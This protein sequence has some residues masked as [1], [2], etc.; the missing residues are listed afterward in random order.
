MNPFKAAKQ[1]FI[2]SRRFDRNVQVGF[3]KDFHLASLPDTIGLR[4]SGRTFYKVYLN[5]EFVFYGP[6]RAAHEHARVDRIDV[7]NQVRIGDNILAIEVA[8]YNAG[9][10]YVTGEYSFLMAE[11]EADGRMLLH[12]DADWSGVE[13]KQK[14][15]YAENYSHARCVSEIYDLD[16]NYY[17]WRTLDQAAFTALGIPLLPTEVI[18]DPLTFLVRGAGTPDYQTVKYVRMINVSSVEPATGTDRITTLPMMV[19]TIPETP[20]QGPIERPVIDCKNDRDIPFSGRL[21]WGDVSGPTNAQEL[22][23]FNDHGVTAVDFDFVEMASA[24]PGLEFTADHPLTVDLI[25]VDK[26]TP[27]GNFDPLNCY[28]ITVIRLHCEAGRYRFEAFEPYGVRYLRVVVRG[29]K[30]FTLHDV[31]LRRCQYP[32]LKGGSFLCS[33]SALNRIYDAA[34]LGLRMNTFDN[35]MD[36]PGRERGGWASDSFWTARAARLLY[37]DTKVERAHLEN[38]LAGSVSK[39]FPKNIPACYPAQENCCIQNWTLFLGLEL[40]EYYRRTADREFL[41]DRAGQV[42]KL[43]GTL[44]Q[45]ENKHGLLE[46]LA[47][48]IYV[49]GTT[50]SNDLYNRPISTATNATY[51]VMLQ[52]LGEIYN[53][54]DWIATAD[55]ILTV[56]KQVC[57]IQDT[58]DFGHY[59]PD[60]FAMDDAGTITS[61]KHSSE[62][63]QYLLMWLGLINKTK[64]PGLCR[65]MI[66]EFGVNPVVPFSYSTSFLLRMSTVFGSCIRFEVLHESGEYEKLFNEMAKIYTYMLDHGPGTLWEG[67]ERHSNINHGYQSHAAVWLIK[68]F[69]GLNIPDEV[70]KTIEIAPH[71]CGRQWAKGYTV[72]GDGIVSVAWEAGDGRFTMSVAVPDGY[73][74]T[75]TLPEEIFGWDNE[76]VFAGTA[77]RRRLAPGEK[78]VADLRQ[79]FRLQAARP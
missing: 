74:V 60:A 52:R 19:R 15:G 33:D 46:E 8:G 48:I 21:A 45:Y 54:E 12:T 6:A 20:E 23:V 64:L 75:L 55:K 79:S 28:S 36:C 18:H 26:L 24:F 7:R 62:G 71:P 16:A 31:F 34:R 70:D 25:H 17:R 2:K 77:E 67:W 43:V 27:E 22:E 61:G 49:D 72:A 3:R 42:E 57:L 13:L 38:F 78:R 65:L 10:L 1:I 40:Y 69:L 44:S 37:G 53:R 63:S 39:Y 58:T 41:R 59:V 29:A 51:A 56:L 76:L 9:N 14:R 4:I 30:H 32:D 47:E 73:R 50:S 66:E 5:G 11:L 68:S 35:F